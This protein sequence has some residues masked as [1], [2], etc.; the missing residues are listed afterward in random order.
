MAVHWRTDGGTA[1]SA[2]SHEVTQ[3]EV[4]V[5]RESMALPCLVSTQGVVTVPEEGKSELAC[6]V[7]DTR[8]CTMLFWGLPRDEKAIGVGHVL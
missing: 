4:T 7:Q 1:A 2:Q 8:W 6:R 3:K 5:R